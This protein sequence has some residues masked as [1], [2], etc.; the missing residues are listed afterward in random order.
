LKPSY[1]KPHPFIG[2]TLRGAFGASL[3]KVVCINPSFKCE[4][5]F[6]KNNCLFYEFYE[7]RNS[8]HGYRFDFELN[9][10]NY[11]FSLYLFEDATDKLPYVVSALH[12]MLTEQGLGR[13]RETFEIERIVCNDRAIYDG[14]EFN[15][16]N[17]KPQEFTIDN[18]PKKISLKLSTPLR[19]KYK[20][21]LL[22]KKPPLESL[23][24][25]IQNRLCEIQKRPK[26]KLTFTPHYREKRSNV[27]FHDQTRRSNRQKTKLQI[28]GVI[29]NI[30]YEEIDE[31]SLMMLKLG[32]ILGVGKQTVFGM[33]KI[34][35]KS[36]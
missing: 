28:G 36:L 5:C 34:E 3:K 15:L 33:G 11:D 10:D 9:Q 17:L 31:K 6:A 27:R 32:E 20:N 12:K 30:D 16:S 1:K 2:S 7:E 22:N 29:G 26:V 13:E 8:A 23:L 24:Y 35:V 25:S 18:L 21:R 4:G 14:R 19:M